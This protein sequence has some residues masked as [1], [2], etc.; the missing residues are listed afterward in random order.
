MVGAVD[1]LGRQLEPDAHGD[2]PLLCPVVQVSL[3][4]AALV[5]GRGLDART[6]VLHLVQQGGG[7]QTQAMVVDRQLR[8]CHRRVDKRTLVTHASS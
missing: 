3:D 4:P 8:V 7:L 6:R 1:A 2:Q 5:V